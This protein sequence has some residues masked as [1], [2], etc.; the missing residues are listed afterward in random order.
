MQRRDEGETEG[1]TGNH[2]SAEI[3]VVIHSFVRFVRFIWVDAR[4]RGVVSLREFSLRV[5]AR[6]ANAYINIAARVK[7]TGA[8]CS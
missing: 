3:R 2:R 4:A 6:H 7:Y 8:A 1:K 5:L